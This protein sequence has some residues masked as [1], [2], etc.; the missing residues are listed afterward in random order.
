MSCRWTA[1]GGGSAPANRTE[2]KQT[3][4]MST[5]KR[6]DRTL[7]LWM[8]YDFLMSSHLLMLPTFTTY[9]L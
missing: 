2:A 5:N 7:F 4:H 3:E 6:T 1:L 8:R 9:T